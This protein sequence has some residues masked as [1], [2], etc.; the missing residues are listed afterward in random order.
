MN[1]EMVR[2]QSTAYVL[3][4]NV[5]VKPSELHFLAATGVNFP[6]QS[7]YMVRWSVCMYGVAA[8]SCGLPSSENIGS[9]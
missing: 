7:M 8:A 6:S 4:Q 2:C 3:W 1:F 5:W 9:L